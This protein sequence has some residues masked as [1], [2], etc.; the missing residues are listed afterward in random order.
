MAD[1]EPKRHRSWLSRL[2]L[3]LLV[4]LA[5]D[6]LLYPRVVGPVGGGGNRRENG[7]WLRYTWYFG[8][9]WPEELAALARR[10]REA[11]VRYA[12]CHVRYIGQKGT[13]RYRDDYQARRLVS[14]LH[15]AAP[16]VKAFAWVYIGNAQGR[17]GVDLAHAETRA[18]IVQEARWLIKQCGFDG[19]QWDYEVCD[20]WDGGLLAL[21]EETRAAL[22]KTPISVCTPPWEPWP[23]TKVYGWDAAYFTAVAQRCDQLAVMDYDTGLYVP[24]WYVGFTREQVIR[25]TAAAAQGNPACRVL[26]GV[27]TYG[28]GTNWGHHAQA[29]SLPMALRGVSAGAATLQADSPFAGVAVFADYTTSQEEWEAYSRYWPEQPE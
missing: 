27:P 8:E 6:Y 2:L 18:A 10:M 23:V 29:E 17:T 20:N 3:L 9:W 22:P 7:I 21:L 19:I 15:R 14:S 24:R 13:L 12:Y 25:V 1:D 4:L 5:A 28:E 26:I 16:G 11:G